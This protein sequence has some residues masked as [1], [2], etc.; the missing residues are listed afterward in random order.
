MAVNMIIKQW[1]KEFQ[2][3]TF[4]SFGFEITSKNRLR[5]GRDP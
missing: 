2:I 4:N 3:I 1:E 5:L